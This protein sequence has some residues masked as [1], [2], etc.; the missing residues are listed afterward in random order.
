MP[1][2]HRCVTLHIDVTV[3]TSLPILPRHLPSQVPLLQHLSLDCELDLNMWERDEQ[4]H[5]FLHAPLRFEGNSPNA[6]EFEFRPSLKT[7]SIDGRNVQN[8]FAKGY[9]WLSEMYEL[10][11]LKVS[12][13]MP[14]VMSRRHPPTDNTADR[15][16]CQKCETFPIPLLAALESCDQLAALTFESIFFEIDPVEENHP[17]EMYDLSSLYSIVMRDMEPVMINEIFRVVDHSSQSV[18]FVQCPRLNE[19][20]LLFKFNPTLQLVYLEDNFDMASFLEGWEC[21]N[22]FITSCPSFSDT[23]L[24]ML[25]VQEGLLPNGRPHFPRCKLLTDLHLH[26]PDSYPPYTVGALKRFMEARGRGVDYSDEDWPYADVGAPLERLIITGN[27][28]DLLEDDEVWFRSH[29][30]KF[31]WGG[32]PDA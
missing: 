8:I 18:A 22:L 23:V 26:Y 31:Q 3:S 30:V 17:D 6:L 11:E 15:H 20:T 21:E 10:S 16:T 27:L 28:P 14:M 2:I 13:Y 32:D 12:N 5:I 1:H 4:K 25:A 7:L 24:D 29:L 19:V 9:T